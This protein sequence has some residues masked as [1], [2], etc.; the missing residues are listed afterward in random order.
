MG[1]MWRRWGVRRAVLVSL[2]VV[3]WKQLA[4]S[5]RVLW[6]EWYKQFKSL[7]NST[8]VEDG[9]GCLFFRRFCRAFGPC[10][11]APMQGLGQWTQGLWWSECGQGMGVPKV[12]SL[13]PSS[14]HAG[15]KSPALQDCG[16]PQVAGC[17]VPPHPAHHLHGL[18]T[19]S[20]GSAP[21]LLLTLKSAFATFA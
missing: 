11:G 18:E 2:E 19:L 21:L 8:Y 15:L 6:G 13:A 4:S 10:L 5:L 3:C 9:C 17:G 1:S 20:S 14:H 16:P 12:L 7:K